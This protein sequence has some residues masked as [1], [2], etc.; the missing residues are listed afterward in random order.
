MA[1]DGERAAGFILYGAALFLVDALG[2]RGLV[3]TPLAV[4]VALIVTLVRLANAVS[5]R[6][7]QK[8]PASLTLLAVTVF[9]VVFNSAWLRVDASFTRR[10]AE[11]IIDAVYRYRA[12]NGQYPW[13]LQPVA[14]P[15]LEDRFDYVVP[16][17]G[18]PNLN[19]TLARGDWPSIFHFGFDCWDAEPSCGH[20][21]APP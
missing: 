4:L 13:S 17:G 18:S 15:W 7:L 21:G 9:C 20:R 10:R 14:P 12:R 11:R 6:R 3:L 19:V 2:F 1:D 16:L 5:Q 8:I